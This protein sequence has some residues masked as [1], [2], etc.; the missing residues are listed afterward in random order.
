MRQIAIDLEN[1][2]TPRGYPG[3]ESLPL[4]QNYL[5]F[6][7]FRG[8]SPSLMRDDTVPIVPVFVPKSAIAR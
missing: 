1:R 7:S 3:F 6:Q 8:L 5:G 2:C 4:R